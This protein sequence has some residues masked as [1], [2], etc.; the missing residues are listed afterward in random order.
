M[1]TDTNQKIA[2]YSFKIHANC[3]KDKV[4]INYGF[5]KRNFYVAFNIV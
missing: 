2:F 1:R 5:K 4:K 3:N